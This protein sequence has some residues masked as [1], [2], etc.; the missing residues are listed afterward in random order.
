VKLTLD[1]FMANAHAEL[2]AFADATRRMVKADPAAFDRKREMPDWWGE[3]RAYAVIAEC[4]G[5]A[6]LEEL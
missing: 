5:D 2:A 4:A 1:E 6:P 3:V